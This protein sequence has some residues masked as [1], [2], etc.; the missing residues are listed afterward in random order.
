VGLEWRCWYDA[1]SK[2]IFSVGLH[3]D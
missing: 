1:F 2:F 3:V